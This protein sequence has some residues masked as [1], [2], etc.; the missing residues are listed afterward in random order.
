MKTLIPTL[1]VLSTSMLPHSLQAETMIDQ[2][3]KEQCKY[4]LYG[5]KEATINDQ[6][7]GYLL[8]FIQGVEYMTDKRELSDFFKS[9]TYQMVKERACENTL[10]NSTEKGFQADYKYEVKKLLTKDEQY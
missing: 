9:R 8:G 3:L 1:F 2:L 5:P 7:D 10:E 4:V 6:A